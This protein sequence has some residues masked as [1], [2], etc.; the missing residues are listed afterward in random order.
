MDG[1]FNAAAAAFRRR[2]QESSHG[3]V[4]MVKPCED[5]RTL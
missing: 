1:R 2:L 5:E 4:P 3:E